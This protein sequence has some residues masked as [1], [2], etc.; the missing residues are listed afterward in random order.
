MRPKTLGGQKN[1]PD[2]GSRSQPHRSSEI[3][4]GP[5][6]KQSA[7]RNEVADRNPVGRTAR[8]AGDWLRATST[9]RGVSCSTMTILSNRSSG[10]FQ[11][12]GVNDFQVLGGG[13][14]K[15]TIP[16]NLLRIMKSGSLNSGPK[17]S[18]PKSRLGTYQRPS[19][20]GP[21]FGR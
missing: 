16:G 17:F 2:G 12:S 1:S 4:G 14:T 21:R 3:L 11:N 19:F 5:S 15:N 10:A 6:A 9:G 18:F 7:D 13:A 20:F 8:Q